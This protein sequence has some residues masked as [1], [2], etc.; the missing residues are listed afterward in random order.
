VNRSLSERPIGGVETGLRAGGFCHLFPTHAPP[1]G[2]FV[3]LLAA[4]NQVFRI[5]VNHKHA[6]P[7]PAGVIYELDTDL[8][9]LLDRAKMKAS[10]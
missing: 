9:A 5:L 7:I 6:D 8:T 4:M 10:Q 3:F 2:R 1:I